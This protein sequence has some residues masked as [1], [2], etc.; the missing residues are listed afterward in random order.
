MDL[1]KLMNCPSGTCVR[2]H[3][4]RLGLSLAFFL[5]LASC[6]PRSIVVGQQFG[7]S[8]VLPGSLSNGPL[9]LNKILQA[10]QNLSSDQL[11]S[12][13]RQLLG[14]S[15][16]S[17]ED[18]REASYVLA[19]LLQTTNSQDDLKEALTLF[20]T[21]KQ[22]SSLKELSQ[23]HIS[24]VAAALGQEKVVRKTLESLR[25]EAATPEK[26]AEAEYGLAQSFLRT[27][28]NDKAQ[29]A[30]KKIKQD[31]PQTEYGTGAD[32]YL[33]E[34]AVTKGQSQNGNG[35]PQSVKE[36]I[37]LFNQYLRLSPTGHF[38]YTILDRLRP[39]LTSNPT[40]FTSE[41]FDLYGQAAYAQEKW[42]QALELWQKSKRARVMESA[43]CWVKLGATE[44]AR[45]TLLAAIK[46]NPGDYRYALVGNEIANRLRTPDALKFW[47][48]VL[49]AKPQ[50][51]DAA[52]WNIAKRSPAPASIAAYKELL[53][54]N[55][56]S[57]YA[58][59]SQWWIFWDMVQH[60]KGKD[61]LPLIHVADSA[62][63]RYGTARAAPRFLFWAGKIC[64]KTGS[65][66]QAESFYRKTNNLYPSDYYGFRSL[67]RIAAIHKTPTPYGWG[68][69]NLDPRLASWTW[70]DP[71]A[72]DNRLANVASEP[73]WELVRL[74]EYQE[75]LDLV[76]AQDPELKPWLYTRLNQPRQTI[77][78]AVK[79]LPAG[80]P[81]SDIIWQYAYPL[82]YAKE[83]QSNCRDKR[84]VD[85]CLA[86]AFVR[87]ES[88]YN[89]F[90][91]SS[92][93]AIGLTQ[94]MP[95]TAYG[96]AKR[97]HISVSNASAFFDPALNLQLG[98]DYFS[99]CLSRFH[100]NPVL[101]VASYNG[102]AGSVRTW[103]N[104]QGADDLDAF[105]E[106]IPFRETRDY[107]RKVFRSYWTYYT[108]YK[109]M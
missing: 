95:G 93:K 92:S 23:W 60:K 76:P 12:A 24:E 79:N 37:L 83:I 47:R 99:L 51:S 55:P 18:K 81:T 65:A 9:T 62:A 42:K 45:A 89:R 11:R 21:A 107:V 98:I 87:E 75:S 4:L 40:N 48:Q 105:V 32:Y 70:P 39:L 3:L 1:A 50:N 103:L 106:S 59:E 2:G 22:L 36:G 69:L 20:D 31:Y 8:A 74:G 101:A 16:I 26:R 52:I 66:K 10:R 102:G 78:E 56:H 15:G 88:Y 25:A 104:K 44:R 7:G 94:V 33:G 80:G 63:Q 49:A 54:R 82:L 97:L 91:V 109:K 46:R 73:F 61:L 84:K 6:S 27:S 108:I 14:D 68:R 34:M 77:T 71:R 41:D 64:E 17:K 90:A 100:D 13:L 43:M 58:P 85:N 29:A 86:H 28:E 38:A 67:A 72:L 57:A 35:A 53:N 19:R 96:V 30:F 5:V